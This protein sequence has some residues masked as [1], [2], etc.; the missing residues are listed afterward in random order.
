MIRRNLMIAQG[1][2]PTAVINCSLVGVIEEAKRINSGRI[3]GALHSID[4]ILN[5]KLTDL[6]RERQS[7]L[8]EIRNKPGAALGSSRRKIREE[9]YGHILDVFRKYDVRYFFYIGGNGSMHTAH[10]VDRLARSIGYELKVIGIPKTIDNDLAYTD[11]CPGFGSA[12]RYVAS[13]TREIGLDV[14]SLPP[15]ISIIETLGRNTGWLAAASS[16]AK[17]QDGDAP[18][19]I[20]FPERPFVMESFL[21]DVEKVYAKYG[22]AVI[23]VSEGLKDE[24]GSYIGGVKAE[25]SKDGFGRNLPGGAASF[26]SEKISENLGLRARSEK[27][28]LAART[29]INYISSVDQKEA[30]LVG[31]MALRS[32]VK[33]NSGVMMT[34]ERERGK[35]YRCKVGAVPLE[36]VAIAEKLLPSDYINSDGNY[37]TEAFLE[38]CQPLVG[39]PIRSFSSLKGYKIVDYT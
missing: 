16:L 18:N 12:A 6:G 3:I 23:V 8:K 14:E 7:V 34:L 35:K 29:S 21:S 10:N 20:Y 28:G 1:G 5:E 31:K 13:V 33:G 38:Y 39:K 32:A 37:V 26:L 17:K 19:L 11:H 9:D 24:S 22:R 27:P 25:A 4:G 30:Y 15:P 36:N 2:G